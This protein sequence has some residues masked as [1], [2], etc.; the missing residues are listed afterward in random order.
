MLSQLAEDGIK[1]RVLTNS[2][3][4]ND[5]AVVHAFYAKYRQQLLENG[6]QLYEFLPAVT[7]EE[8]NEVNQEISKSQS[9]HERTQP[10]QPACQNDGTR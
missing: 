3:A 10:L 5:V 1:V 2:Y 4:A 7:D 6:V 9:Q 8:L